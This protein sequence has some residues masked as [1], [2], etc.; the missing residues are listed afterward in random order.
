MSQG[1]F[2]ILDGFRGYFLIFMVVTHFQ[3]MDGSIIG[4]MTHG[5]LGYV[6]DAQGFVFLSGLIVGLHHARGYLTGRARR[7]DGK[8]LARAWLLYRYS[9]GLLAFLFLL[10]LLFPPLQGGWERFYADFFQDP[11]LIGATALTLL[12]QPTYMDI[13]PQYM[14]YLVISPLLLRLVLNGRAAWVIGGSLLVWLP[15]QLGV[16]VPAI[17]GLESLGQNLF[18][19]TFITRAGFNPLGWQ[20]L[21]VSGLVIGA[22]L[23]KDPDRLWSW[24]PA[25]G[26]AALV[27]AGVL[28]AYFLVMRLGQTLSLLP[29]DIV[30][31]F[32][33][34]DNRTTL[35]IVYP[36]NFAALA[37]AMTWTLLWGGQSP[38]RPVRALERS[39][40]WIFTHPFPRL[41]G[42]HSLGV[43]TFH[44]VLV[45]TMYALETA[46][47]PFSELGKTLIT[48]SG[49]TLLLIPSFL[50]ESARTRM[51]AS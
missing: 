7:T 21:Y 23:A 29:L 38:R 16:H 33:V 45:F 46:V 19:P 30:H 8:L 49:I 13:L 14:L 15:T 40:R 3:Y 4:H 36:I 43:Y 1:R 47:G 35:S 9:L 34:L 10:P 39:L 17:A 6:Q 22:T 24:F 42:R 26:G 41:L 12:Y 20:L 31:S 2:E 50:A 28:L 25:G 27:A 51:T 48:L 44:L 37:Y 32:Q 11:T 5:S 18:G